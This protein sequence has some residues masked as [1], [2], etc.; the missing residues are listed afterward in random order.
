MGNR[1]IGDVFPGLV[2]HP[3]NDLQHSKFAEGFLVS[4]QEVH[5]NEKQAGEQAIAHP[6]RG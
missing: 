4:V 2:R 1:D 6:W 5:G 3:G